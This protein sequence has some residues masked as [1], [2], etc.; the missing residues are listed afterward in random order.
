[1]T[2]VQVLMFVGLTMSQP[3]LPLFLENDLGLSRGQEVELW[4]G[5]IA[6]A[7]FLTL[8]IFSPIWGSLADRYGRRIM[9]IRSS[10]AVGVFNLLIVLVANQYQLLGV[11]LGMGVLSGFGASA[12]ALVGAVTPKERLGY[13]LGLMGTGQT[14][15]I[16]FGPLLGGVIS[17]YFGYRIAF[18]FTGVLSLAACLLTAFAVREDFVA[19]TKE[20]LAAKPSL[21]RGMASIARSR[22]LVAMFVVLALNRLT[23]GGVGPITSL[24]VGEL[25]VPENLVPTVAG[26]A[27]SVAGVGAAITAPL[28]GRLADRI[29]YKPVLL[30]ALAGSAV[31]FLPQAWVTAAWQFLAL[32]FGLGLLS[33]GI[34]PAAYAIIGRKAP[35]GQQSAAYGLTFS[36]TAMGNFTGPLLSGV[37]AASFGLRS[38][39]IY[40]SLLVALNAAW[41]AFGVR[42]AAPATAGQAGREAVS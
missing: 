18:L 29:G 25:N 19:P 32:R 1:M 10:A 24:Y 30:V 26:L 20:E 41:V 37:M 27:F 13:A 28:L 2:A 11:R 40:T 39:F 7:H 4:S 35:P 34:Q 16:V 36:A 9:V 33:G 31:F 15:G 21:L 5:I 3:L 22:D 42:E 23:I 6:A 12:T 14:V 8:T 17:T 38:V